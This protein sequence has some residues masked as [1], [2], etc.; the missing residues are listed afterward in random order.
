MTSTM[1]EI[2]GEFLSSDNY[3]ALSISVDGVAMVLLIVLLAE[4]ELVHAFAGPSARASIRAVSI[5]AAPLLLAFVLIV[6]V[7]LMGLRY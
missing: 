2:V 4:I 6:V 3:D 5:V 1:N 7:R